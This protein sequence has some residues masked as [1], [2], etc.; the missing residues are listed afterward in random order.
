[1]S[2]LMSV[3]EAAK[4][5]RKRFRLDKW[6]N[7]LDHFEIDIIDGRP[8]PWVKLWS[9]INGPVCEQENPQ[10]M[11]FTMLGDL[12]AKVWRNYVGPPGEPWKPSSVSPSHS[13]DK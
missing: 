3:N 7:D 10:K 2:E 5:G 1:M 4:L 13:G 9:P 12:D 8:G 6:A 11:L